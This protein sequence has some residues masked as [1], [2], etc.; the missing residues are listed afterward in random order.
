MSHILDTKTKIKLLAEGTAER[1]QQMDLLREVLDGLATHYDGLVTSFG[2]DYGYNRVDS[3]LGLALVIGDRADNQARL[4]RG[5]VLTASPDGFLTFTGDSWRRE[6]EYAHVQQEIEHLYTLLSV[7]QALA[8][9]GASLEVQ[10]LDSFSHQ[11]TG[12]LSGY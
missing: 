1:K 4:P 10:T 6:N 11:L 2:F 5:I 8:Q 3:P 7:Q 12:V 9:L